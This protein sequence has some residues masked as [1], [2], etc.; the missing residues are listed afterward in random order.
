LV[1]SIRSNA[2]FLWRLFAICEGKKKV[3]AKIPKV[4]FLKK[5]GPSV[6]W[7]KV[8]RCFMAIS[9]DEEKKEGEITIFR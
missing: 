9:H 5:I 4:F 7:Q 2:F 6:L 1:L 8:Q 3:G